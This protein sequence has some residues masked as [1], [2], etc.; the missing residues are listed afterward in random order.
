MGIINT[1]NQKLFLSIKDG[2]DTVLN[3]YTVLDAVAIEV[4]AVSCIITQD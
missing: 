2:I 1:P 3:I 4:G